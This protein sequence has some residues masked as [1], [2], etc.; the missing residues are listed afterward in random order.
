MLIK[1][2]WP[3]YCVRDRAPLTLLK[4]LKQGRLVNGSIGKV[5]KFM[6][7]SE[8]SE[9]ARAR[10]DNVGSKKPWQDPLGEPLQNSGELWP[11]VKFLNGMELLVAPEI[12]D[13]TNAYGMMEVQRTQVPLIL[14]WAL[15]IHKSQ[16]QTLE[17]VK[18]NLAKSFTDG[19]GVSIPSLK[20][21]YESLFAD[22]DAVYVA[23]SR[24][25]KLSQLQ[26]LGFNPSK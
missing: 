16:G 13:I 7:W 19:Q 9:S 26:I 22:H 11:Y 25:T 8:V 23:L 2:R 24:A 12:F 10:P 21:L 14:A 4:N 17:R 15:S 5:I 1:V 18:V 6:R 20:G 3:G